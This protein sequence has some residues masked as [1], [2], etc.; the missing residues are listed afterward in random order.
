M[1]LATAI[2]VFALSPLAFAQSPCSSLPH[3]DHPKALLSTGSLDVV[4]FL[5][6]AASGYYRAARFDWAGVIGCVSY[7]GHTFFGEWFSHYDPTL[8]DSITGPVEE[9]RAS[10]SEIGYDQAAPGGSFL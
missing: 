8:N 9:F 10:Q 2:F 1:R 6:D 5:P 4:V 7:K 3:A